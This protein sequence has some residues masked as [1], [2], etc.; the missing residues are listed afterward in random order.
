MTCAAESIRRSESDLAKTAPISVGL[1]VGEG[2]SPNWLKS[3]YAALNA[4]HAGHR[5]NPDQSS[6]V[7]L[8]RCPWC[9]TCLS[10]ADYKMADQ[11]APVIIACPNTNAKCEFRSGIPAVVVDEQIYNERPSLIIGTVDKFARLPWEPRSGD[12]F[13]PT[14]VIPLRSWLSKMNSI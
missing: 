1:W 8:K 4:L 11:N 7:K 12:I 9:G 13:R 10:A 5:L 14:A 2:A 3:A 6:P